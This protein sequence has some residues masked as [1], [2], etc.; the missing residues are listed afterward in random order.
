MLIRINNNYKHILSLEDN[1][2]ID[3]LNQPDVS[4]FKTEKGD[5]LADFSEIVSAETLEETKF[6]LQLDNLLEMYQKVYIFNEHCPSSTSFMFPGEK[7]ILKE[8]FSSN[9][10]LSE[11]RIRK[12]LKTLLT[13]IATEKDIETLSVVALFDQNILGEYYNTNKYAIYNNKTKKIVANEINIFEV[14]KHIEE[15]IFY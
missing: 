2:S 15:S 9:L 10:N 7:Q 3:L 4:T 1:A 8:Y 6:L 13:N 11:I 5:Y 12:M 14:F